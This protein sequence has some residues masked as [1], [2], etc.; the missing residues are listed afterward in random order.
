MGFNKK[1]ETKIVVP[2]VG[3]IYAS[4]VP[5]IN[6]LIDMVF[7]RIIVTQSSHNHGQRLFVRFS[8]YNV[9]QIV[10]QLDTKCFQTITRRGKQKQ[11]ERKKKRTD[12][13]PMY[14]Y[15][16]HITLIEPTYCTSGQIVRIHVR[17]AMHYSYMLPI[18][19]FDR[20]PC[21]RVLSFDGSCIVC[22]APPR[23]VGF[24]MISISFDN[25][26]TFVG[27]SAIGLHYLEEQFGIL[28][29]LLNK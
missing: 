15:P 21:R 11:K 8:L 19:L 20:E 17:G 6:N 10:G 14:V 25:L 16:I 26:Q 23:P 9:D 18:V 22:E 3:K 7:D 5:P 27:N 24:C 1:Q 13:I 12:I 4:S 29:L 28:D 2:E